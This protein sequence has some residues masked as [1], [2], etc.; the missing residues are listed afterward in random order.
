MRTGFPSLVAAGASF[1]LLLALFPFLAAFVSLYGFVANPKTIADQISFLAGLMP[2]GGIDVIKDQLRALAAQERET[3]SLGFLLGLGFRIV[4]RQQRRKSLFEEL[5]IA[6]DE[7]EKRG[8]VRL[9]LVIFCLHIRRHPDRRRL[10]RVGRHRTGHPRLPQP[11][12]LDR[13]ALFGGDDGQ[14]CWLLPQRRCHADLPVRPK[15]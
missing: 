9:N 7:S 3:L 10:H 15:P 6:Y 2:S 1:Y 11:R 14:L 12:T 13:T 5:N 4:E 8:F